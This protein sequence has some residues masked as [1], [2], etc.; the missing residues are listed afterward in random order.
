MANSERSLKAEQD[1]APKR[2]AHPYHTPVMLTVAVGMLN[3]KPDGIYIDATLGGGG[4]SEQI[5]AQLTTGK[6]FGFE[7][8]PN[9]MQFAQSRLEVFGDHFVM[10]PE[11][12]AAIKQAL[13]ERGI[14]AIDG[15]V[16]D[17]GVSGNQLDT[18]SIGLSYRTNA[19]LDMRL[20][21]RLSKSGWHVINE[22]E[23]EVMRNIFFKFGEEPHS[24]RIARNIVH[25]RSE[26]PI[27]T[28]FELAEIITRGI[29]E[30]KRS[31]TL[32]RIFQAIRIE[33]NSEIEN[34]ERSLEDAIR[35][36]APNGRIVVVSYHSLEDRVVKQLLIRES[37]PKALPGSAEYLKASV[38]LAK[39]TLR[40][41][42][43][44]AMAPTDE[45]IA[46]NPRA[47]SAKLR[48]AEKI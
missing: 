39:A 20:D 31:S 17:L 35:L 29:R 7:T 38:D 5:L 21:P 41:L 42:T 33:V 26:R 16:Y 25:V 4:Y 27:E 34:L 36:L 8:D 45:E 46:Q 2:V 24:R 23:E 32:S 12:F 9:A 19:K 48:A 28:T 10:V 43:K 22:Y 18:P 44:K 37:A 1:E 11:N 30:D 3:I 6:L 13:D 40:L 47:R 14:A 15:I